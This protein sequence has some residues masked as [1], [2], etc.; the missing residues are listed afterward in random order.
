[1][2]AV[3]HVRSTTDLFVMDM[4]S[5]GGTFVDDKKT[6]AK[7]K[8]KSKSVIKVGETLITV[9]VGD[10]IPQPEPV[11]PPT[12]PDAAAPQAGEGGMMPP[13]L[14]P[15]DGGMPAPSPV[16][17]QAPLAV[18]EPPT[19]FNLAMPYNPNYVLHPVQQTPCASSGVLTPQPTPFPSNSSEAGA[20]LLLEVVE[21]LGRQQWYRED[22]VW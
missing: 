15:L 2:H 20:H 1:M 22:K 18:T 5:A 14:P 4:G 11:S 16:A 10:D 6:G 12:L 21:R 7:G 17:T 9:Y 13:P 8:V 19:T 3:I